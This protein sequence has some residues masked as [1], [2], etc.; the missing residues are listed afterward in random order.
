MINIFNFNLF[1]LFILFILFTFIWFVLILV[2]YSIILE[3]KYRNYYAIC[4]ITPKYFLIKMDLTEGGLWIIAGRL[5]CFIN[6]GDIKDSK[7]N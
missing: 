4:F 1:S 2:L 3:H 5:E 7:I 6:R